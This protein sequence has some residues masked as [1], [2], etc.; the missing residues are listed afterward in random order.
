VTL[1]F[2]GIFLK[3]MTSTLFYGEGCDA[4]CAFSDGTAQLPQRICEERGGLTLDAIAVESDSTSSR[5]RVLMG[6]YTC[7]L[8][9]PLS[10]LLYFLF[11][12]AQKVT[13][14]SIKFVDRDAGL[15]LAV[16][17][18]TQQSLHHLAL[19][20]SF[21]TWKVTVTELQVLHLRSVLV[22]RRIQ[23]GSLRSLEVSQLPTH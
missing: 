23:V 20:S 13:N 11:S 12:H 7:L 1:L 9:L 17:M 16:L 8:T 6:V 15:Q 4:P 10:G 22:A 5:S 2:L 21:Y 19:T 18:A 3:M 14:S